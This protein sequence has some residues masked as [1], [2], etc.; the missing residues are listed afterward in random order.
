MADFNSR[1]KNF[2]NKLTLDL[3]L[4]RYENED[5]DVFGKCM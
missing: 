2:C 1:K 3:L 4:E 5:I